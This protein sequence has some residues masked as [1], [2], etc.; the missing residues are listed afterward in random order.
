MAIKD[1]EG[2]VY[3]SLG[4]LWDAE[5]GTDRSKQDKWYSAGA[6]YWKGV[7][8]TVDGM[9]GGLAFVSPADIQGSIKTLTDLVRKGMSRTTCLDCGAGI[10]R[11]SQEVLARVFRQVDL[12]EQDQAFVDRAREELAGNAQIRHFFAVGM[13]SFLWKDPLS[14]ADGLQYD[15]VWIQWVIGHLTDE[16]LIQFL[17][18]ARSSLTPGGYIVIKDNVCHEG[19]LLD[20]ED[21]SLMRT[22]EAVISLCDKSGLMVF[23]AEKQTYFPSTI[24]PV[25]TIVLKVD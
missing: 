15:C 12:L 7:D 6:S 22:L 17:R 10:G 4:A 8:G 23:S 14:P 24:F 25:Y 2:K 18:N 21:H 1:T 3:P 11:V 5:L 19:Y 9:L 16:D 13:Q 20:V